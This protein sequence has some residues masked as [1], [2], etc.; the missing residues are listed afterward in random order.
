MH[1]VSVFLEQ[2]TINSCTQTHTLH[3]EISA[4]LVLKIIRGSDSKRET[5]SSEQK[6]AKKKLQIHLIV[7]SSG[8]LSFAHLSICI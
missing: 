5:T 7:P 6:S 2:Y 1:Y 4:S 3:A 8:T